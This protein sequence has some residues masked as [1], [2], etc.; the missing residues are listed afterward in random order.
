MEM[1][2]KYEDVEPSF[3]EIEGMAWVD[4]TCDGAAAH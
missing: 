2:M 1:N 3:Q 4:H